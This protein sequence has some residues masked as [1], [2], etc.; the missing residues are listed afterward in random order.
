MNSKT[1]GPGWQ[2]ASRSR[3]AWAANTLCARGANAAGPTLLAQCRAQFV[4]DLLLRVVHRQRLIP[5]EAEVA[6][7]AH[8]QLAGQLL[9]AEEGLQLL[10]LPLLLLPRGLRGRHVRGC[11]AHNVPAPKRDR[12]ARAGLSRRAG[13]VSLRLAAQL[14]C[15]RWV[16][17]ARGCRD[18][19]GRAVWHPNMDVPTIMVKIVYNCSFVDSGVTSP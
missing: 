1:D 12:D 19:S 9:L 10:Q 7:D 4:E 2:S 16:Q 3:G 15:A 5:Q 6:A 18:A 8:L 17:L 13:A 14:G 11:Q